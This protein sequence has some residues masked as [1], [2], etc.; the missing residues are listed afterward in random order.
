[1]CRSDTAQGLVHSQRFDRTPVSTMTT[2]LE[3]H[4]PADPV[5]TSL[6]K[7]QNNAS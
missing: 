3:R 7:Q 1:M 5:V 2:G 6:V 4:F